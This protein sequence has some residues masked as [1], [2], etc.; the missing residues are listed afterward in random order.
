MKPIYIIV[1]VTFDYHRFQTNL[2]VTTHLGR[3]KSIAGR[4][5]K[6]R[7]IPIFEYHT[8]D[9]PVIEGDEMG[10]NHIWIQEMK[11]I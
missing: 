9:G 6:D 5:A 4:E 2:N 1:H 10:E 7:G 8:L 3:A 11:N